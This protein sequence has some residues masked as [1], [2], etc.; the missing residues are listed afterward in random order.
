MNRNKA[1]ANRT[2]AVPYIYC[3]MCGEELELMKKD[4]KWFVNTCCSCHERRTNKAYV[5]GYSYALRAVACVVESLE[6]CA[7]PE[8]TRS[9]RPAENEAE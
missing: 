9:A 6:R 7:R 3:D 5:E 8:M 2:M 1:N 4:G